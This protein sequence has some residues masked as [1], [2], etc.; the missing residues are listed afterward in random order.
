M[1]LIIAN[2]VDFA[3]PRI[4]EGWDIVAGGT[5]AGW[6]AAAAAATKAAVESSS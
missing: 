4:A 6:V 5:D 1:T 2:D 3:R